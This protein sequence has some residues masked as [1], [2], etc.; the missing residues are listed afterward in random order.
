M[1]KNLFT[2]IGLFIFGGLVLQVF[3][4]LESKYYVEALISL[5]AGALIYSGLIMLSR[6]NRKAWLLST[7][8]LAG[9]AIV[10]IF[11]SPHLFSH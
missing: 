4:Q 3:I 11:L 8:V 1:E 10:M 2:W 5:A 9:A 7:S 6:K